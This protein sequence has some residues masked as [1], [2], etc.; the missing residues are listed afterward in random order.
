MANTWGQDQYLTMLT[1]AYNMLV[2][3]WDPNKHSAFEADDLGF[4]FYTDDN[5]AN[6]SSYKCTGCGHGHGGS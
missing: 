5:S 1:G 2:N 6:D 4:S 3:Y